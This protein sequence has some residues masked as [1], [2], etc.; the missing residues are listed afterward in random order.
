MLRADWR[1]F[2]ALL[3]P[4]WGFQDCTGLTEI[5]L[6][7][8]I[9][10]VSKCLFQG[11]T[12]LTWV[13]IPVSVKV[14]EQNAFAGCGRLVEVWQLRHRGLTTSRAYLSVMP[15]HTRHV[16]CSRNFAPLLDGC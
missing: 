4:N 10:T 12:R 7:S 2:G 3:C 8:G 15:L 11:C 9:E 5:T 16:M 1:T 6:P 14:I 13:C